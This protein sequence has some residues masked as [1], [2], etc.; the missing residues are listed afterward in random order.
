MGFVFNTKKQLVGAV[1]LYCKNKE[2]CIE[3]YGDTNT[4]DVSR[5]TDMAQLFYRTSFDGEIGNWD[6][7]NVIDMGAMFSHSDFN[8]DISKWNVLNVIDMGAMFSCSKFN[9]DIGNWDVSN[10]K[11]MCCMFYN[12]QFDGDISKWN[13]KYGKNVSRMFNYSKFKGDISEWK[14]HSHDTKLLLLD[15]EANRSVKK[16]IIDKSKIKSI[17]LVGKSKIMVDKSTSTTYENIYTSDIL[18]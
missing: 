3:K 13:V 2:K 8:N 14:L 12:S 9:N 1:N 16:C 10:V 17:E 18:S 11:N 6:V 15:I 5:I 4:W 7:S